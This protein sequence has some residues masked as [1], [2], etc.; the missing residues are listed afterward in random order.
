VDPFWA[1]QVNWVERKVFVDMTREMVK[2]SPEFDPSA[3]VN[4]EYEVRLYDFC[5]RPKYWV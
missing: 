1:D 4:R 5:G 2:N 3:P